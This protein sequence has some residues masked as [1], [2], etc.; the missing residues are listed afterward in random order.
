MFGLIEELSQIPRAIFAL[1]IW[2][3]L[4]F[5]F[6]RTVIKNVKRSLRAAEIIRTFLIPEVSDNA[7]GKL[8][9]SF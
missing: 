3:T 8:G 5:V 1:S 2:K 4:L 7:F 9:R 6:S